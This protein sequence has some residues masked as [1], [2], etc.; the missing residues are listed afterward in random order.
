VG[1]VSEGKKWQKELGVKKNMPVLAITRFEKWCPWIH[2]GRGEGNR[3]RSTGGITGEEKAG[4]REIWMGVTCGKTPNG[5]RV[6]VHGH[7]SG[8]TTTKGGRKEGRAARGE[9]N[10][11][12]PGDRVGV[13]VE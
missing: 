11:N 10:A 4:G 3:G 8:C 7:I 9:W 12:R 6:W 1:R 5:N 13:G 2:R